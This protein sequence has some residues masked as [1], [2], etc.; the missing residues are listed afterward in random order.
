MDWKVFCKSPSRLAGAPR[1]RGA[2]SFLRTGLCHHDINSLPLPGATKRA[3]G[4]LIPVCYAVTYLYGAIGAV[5]ILG[6]LGPR[7]PGGLEKVRQQTREL[8]KQLSHSALSNAP[9]CISG[10]NPLSFRAHRVDSEHFNEPR[11]IRQ[12]EEHFAGQG[13]RIFVERVRT[14]DKLLH[15]ASPDLPVSKDDAIVI[16]GRHEYIIQD[17]S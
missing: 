16:P 1:V 15:E 12:I 9:P 7:M 17:E 11:T 13:K 6:T 3:W 5:R 8:E 4:A 10:A 2:S 14:G